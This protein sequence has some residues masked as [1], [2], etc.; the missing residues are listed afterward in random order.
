[1]VAS[2]LHAKEGNVLADGGA[3]FVVTTAGRAKDLTDTIV[4][5]LGFG[6]EVIHYSISQDTDLA[7]LGFDKAA[8]DAYE[9]AG[10]GPEDV[11]VAELYDAYPVVPLITLEGLGLCE[12]GEAGAFIYEGNTWPGGKLPMTTNGGM[13]GQGH[14]AA[15]GGIAILVEACR[16]LMGKA[17]QRQVKDAKIAVETSL[18]GTYMDSHVTILGKEL[19]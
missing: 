10:I 2:P 6:G 11:D 8:K 4:Y 3:A 19:S 14:T 16:Q 9:M 5:P 13:L 7:R 18:G 17:G 12:R 15:G 1:M